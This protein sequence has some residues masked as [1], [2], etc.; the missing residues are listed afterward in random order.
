MT[1][2]MESAI[3]WTAA[4]RLPRGYLLAHAYGRLLDV[5]LLNGGEKSKPWHKQNE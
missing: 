1:E 4:R 2:D 3:L 5:Y